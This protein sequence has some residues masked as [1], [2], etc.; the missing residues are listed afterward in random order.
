MKRN[1]KK[2]ISCLLPLVLALVFIA[3]TSEVGMMLGTPAV[4]SYVLGSDGDYVP[5]APTPTPTPVKKKAAKKTNPMKV[6]G[7]TVTILYKNVSVKTRY[8]TRKTAMKITNAKG[9]VTY[10]KRSGNKK[11]T[12]NKSTGKITVKKGLKKGTY[13]F[14]VYVTASG[15]TRYKKKTVLRTVTIK[16]VKA[17][18]PMTVTAED[19]TID[20]AELE[21]DAKVL[22]VSSAVTV[23]NAQGAVK[24][25]KSSGDDGITVDE[26]T[27]DIIV[28]KGMAPGVYAL[29]I[30]VT[31]AGNTKYSSGTKYAEIAV[32][33]T[34]PATEPGTDPGTETGA[35]EGTGT[36]E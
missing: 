30:K 21:N 17:A 20:A 8:I 31:A 27:G 11:I 6:T 26:A 4:T 16:V 3:G 19:I 9:K 22:P 32:F 33:I 25:A 15:T 23:K 18:N 24:Y 10:R 14:K 29:E 2:I 36:S 12:I 35:E 34:E 7:K 28:S 1:L 5:P 13:K